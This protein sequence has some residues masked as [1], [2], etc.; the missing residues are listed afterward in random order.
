M[1]PSPLN[2]MAL[3]TERSRPLSVLLVDDDATVV[4]VTSAFLEREIDSVE[5]TTLTDPTV[6]LGELADGEYD[7]VVSDFDMPGL[8]GLEL[9]SAI[10]QEGIKIPFVLFTGK[11]SEE[12]A[13]RAISAGVDEYLQKG[14]PEE[15]P[16]LANKIE[17]LVE[18]HWAETQVRR[19]FLAIESAE[20]GIA[21]IDDEGVYQYVNEAYAAVYN[22]D[23]A[24]LVGEHWDM[25]YPPG[26][27]KRFHDEILPKLQSEGTW[28]GVSTGVTKEGPPVP[29]RLVLTQMESGGHVCIVQEI[30]GGDEPRGEIALKHQALF[31]KSPDLIAVHDADGIIRDV[32]KRMCAELGYAES[33]LVGKAVWEIDPTADPERARAFW[34]GISTDSPRRFEG[35]LERRDGSTFPI[36][37]HLIR[38][39]LDGKDRFVAMDRDIT[40]QREREAALVRQNER[41]DRFTSVVSHDLRN[42]LQVATGR[43]ELLRENCD[44][45][46]V[47][48]IGSALDR[49]D[50]LIEDLLTL[51]QDGEAAMEMGPVELGSLVEICWSTVATGEATLSV[52]AALTVEADRDQL[53]QLFENLIRNAVEHGGD[54]VTVTVGATESGFYREDDG[55]GVPESERGEIFEM[56]YSTGT[57]GTGFGLSIVERIVDAHGWE[58][59]VTEGQ[60]GGAR[61]EVSGAR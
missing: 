11:G 14:G 3:F 6:T 17:N 32:N 10:R 49:M 39:D 36:E 7:C 9:L 20:E 26:E 15:Y 53:Q 46:H 58:I 55:P 35:K 13:S 40:D 54:D 18:K 23:R 45:E 8:D 12:I 28:R 1:A 34:E 43:L 52:E 60:T 61:F 38:L 30:A 59:A 25:L 47:G 22:R 37:V 50:D 4:E 2:E 33:E 27:A 5:T 29:E 48:P 57:D 31:E 24:E 19:G 56:G 44:S 42:P 41:L 16:V 21:I 51:A